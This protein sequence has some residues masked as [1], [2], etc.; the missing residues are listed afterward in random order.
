MMTQ[1]ELENYVLE[2]EHTE[3]VKCPVSGRW[4]CRYW[5]L[6]DDSRI[7]ESYSYDYPPE[8][9]DAYLGR[10]VCELRQEKA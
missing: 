5:Q 2:N 7:V 10:K 4:T 3:A 6:E 9:E 1:E 8:H